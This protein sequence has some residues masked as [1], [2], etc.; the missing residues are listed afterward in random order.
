MKI[1]NPTLRYMLLAGCLL[2]LLAWAAANPVVQVQN[3]YVRGLPPGTTNTA[4]YMTLVNHSDEDLVLTGAVS[5][6]AGSAMLHNT[7]RRPGGVLGMEHVMSVVL[8]AHGK[9][10]L[11][12]GGMHLMLMGLKR[13]L[14]DGNS[15]KLTL[16]F[17]GGI[18]LDVELPVVSVLNE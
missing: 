3:G 8:P 18:S 4:A 17:E 5:P 2:P 12:S 11:K 13:Q 7:V 14:R 10:E 6:D 15:V 16:Q 9:L 1:L